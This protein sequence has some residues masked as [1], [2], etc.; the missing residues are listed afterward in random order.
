MTIL[1]LVR[2]ESSDEGVRG[3]AF[4][5]IGDGEVEV[6]I[7]AII[8][9]GRGSQRSERGERLY[10][11]PLGRPA[12]LSPVDLVGLEV[13]SVGHLFDLWPS[14]FLHTPSKRCLCRDC[15][16]LTVGHLSTVSIFPARS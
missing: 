1:C 5:F 10:A 3:W 8:A 2:I 4:P 13:E 11:V 6:I 7:Y 16:V 9:L 12:L 14:L 15:Q